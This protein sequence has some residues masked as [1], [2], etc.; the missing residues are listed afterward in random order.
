MQRRSSALVGVKSWVRA[1]FGVSGGRARDPEGVFDLRGAPATGGDGWRG[2]DWSGRLAV[3]VDE[4]A[5]NVG[6]FDTPDRF[7]VRGWGFGR[8]DGHVEVD[9]AV[10]PGGVVVGEVLGQDVFEVAAIPY[11]YPV[12]AFGPYGAYPALGVRVGLRR[13]WRDLD[14]VDAGCGEHRV[15]RGAELRV[16]VG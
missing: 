5:E 16:P 13:P 2:R 8:G 4:A 7:E 15:E 1:A 14:Y 6:S 12:E 9:A 3:F 10:R 11:Q